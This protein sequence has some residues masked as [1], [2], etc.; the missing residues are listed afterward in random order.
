MLWNVFVR[1]FV[2][3][4]LH[5]RCEMTEGLDGM[6]VTVTSGTSEHFGERLGVTVL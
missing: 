6:S 1:T 3:D 5:Q 4:G 2:W